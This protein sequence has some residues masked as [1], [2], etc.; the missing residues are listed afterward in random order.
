[1]MEELENDKAEED[2]EER[3]YDSDWEPL[4]GH[5]HE[6]GHFYWRVWSEAVCS[7]V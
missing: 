2:D 6:R 3:E 4:C 5:E 7:F 1:M